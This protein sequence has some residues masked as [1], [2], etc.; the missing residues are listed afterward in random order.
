MTQNHKKYLRIKKIGATTF[1]DEFLIFYFGQFLTV[2][3]F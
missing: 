2:Y 3:Y 1:Q